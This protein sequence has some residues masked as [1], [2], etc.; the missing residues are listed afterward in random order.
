MSS[1][2]VLTANNIP[3][4]ELRLTL[5]YSFDQLRFCHV[6]SSRLDSYLEPS[7]PADP[8]QLPWYPNS[9]AALA[10]RSVELCQTLLSG[11]ILDSF[12]LS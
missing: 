10:R 5:G 3:I 7:D 11:L 4:G 9:E 1:N 8:R 2:I 12:A 6:F